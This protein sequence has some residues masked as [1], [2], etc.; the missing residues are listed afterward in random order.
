MKAKKRQTLKPL[1]IGQYYYDACMVR[2]TIESEIDLQVAMDYRLCFAKMT[3]YNLHLMALGCE[4]FFADNRWHDKGQ[5]AI[6]NG[7]LALALHR[8]SLLIHKD[9]SGMVKI[10]FSTKQAKNESDLVWTAIRQS[11]CGG[12]DLTETTHDRRQRA[13]IEFQDWRAMNNSG[14]NDSET[15]EEKIARRKAMLAQV[16]SDY[17]NKPITCKAR[18]HNNI[19]ANRKKYAKKIKTWTN[20]V[21]RRCR[22]P[23]LIPVGQHSDPVGQ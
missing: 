5:E 1:E 16:L 2:H 9:E 23:V 15:I 6:Q 18:W 22:T 19:I 17:I 21:F 12:G 10:D 7:M 8:K 11:F 20:C 13:A 3:N 4:S 14:A